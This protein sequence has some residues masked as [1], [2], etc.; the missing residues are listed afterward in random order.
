MKAILALSD[1]TIYRGISIGVGGTTIGEVVFNT[2]M[3]GYQEI[4]TDP[5][6]RGQIVALTYPLIGN[7]GVNADDMESSQ[8]QVSGFVVKELCDSPSNFRS[9]ATGQDFLERHQIVGIQGIDVRALTKKI[10][11]HGVMMSA[12]STEHTAAELMELVENAP[13]YDQIDFV[14][15]VSCQQAY[16]WDRDETHRGGQWSMEFFAA[17]RVVVLD[18]GVKFNILRSLRSRGCEV[19]VMPCTSTLEEMLRW[20]PT[21]VLLSNG[22][23]DP[24]LLEYA[25]TN[26]RNMIEYSQERYLPIMGICLGN[27]LLGTA[28]GGTTYRLKFGHRGANH[29]VKDLAT[30]RVYITSQNHGYALADEGLPSEVEV[31]HINLN[32]HTVEGLRHKRLPIFSVQYHPEASPGPRDNSYLFDHFVQLMSAHPAS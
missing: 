19:I 11:V 2:S 26:I 24:S 3:T 10:R 21:G 22:P 5:S 13:S 29:P 14:R 12:L 27:Q 18:Y 1:G 25:I 16:Q 32:D 20:E 9:A 28:F 17:N 8:P 6:Y 30:G 23:G 7:Y 15:R 4:L 31:S